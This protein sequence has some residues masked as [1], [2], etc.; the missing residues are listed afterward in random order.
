MQCAT[1]LFFALTVGT[2][3]AVLRNSTTPLKSLLLKP[4]SG[5]YGFSNCPCVGIDQLEGK[6]MAVIDPKT[7]KTAP[8]PAD[9]GA[10]CQAWDSKNHPK[11]P[12]ES[13]CESKWCYVDPCNCEK[14]S[15]YPKPANYLPDSQYQG[16][17]VHFSYATCDGMDSYSETGAGSN[18]E[19]V[20]KT[21]AVEVD[22]N[23]WGQE[24]CRCVGFAPQAGTMKVNVDGKMV[25]FPADTGGNCQAWEKDNHPECK[26]SAPPAWCSQ[27][28]CY[29]DPCK[30]K[31]GVPPRTTSY[32]PDANYQGRPVYYSYD[33]CGAV[34][35]WTSE[36]SKEACVNQE[37]KKAC[38]KLD[39]CLWREEKV[40]GSC[41]GKELVEVCSG[42]MGLKALMVFALPLLSLL[43]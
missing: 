27:A 1:I 35:S 24:D 11:C 8:Y 37:D 16:K 33:T 20:E 42:A 5:P 34:D 26:S 43:Y 38:A 28:W 3:A 29:V 2:E 7:A 25:D 17:P 32:I 6:T 40:G 36:K 9:M 31:T 30:C 23:L 12:G 21:C 39:K 14:V 18:Y 13:W 4:K 15:P 22:S 19:T 41:L 10:S